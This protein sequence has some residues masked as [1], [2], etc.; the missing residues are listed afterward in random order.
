MD[1]VDIQN[2][3]LLVNRIDKWDL[4]LQLVSITGFSL[5]TLVAF[6]RF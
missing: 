6:W 5:I 2:R 1:R 4:R 3:D